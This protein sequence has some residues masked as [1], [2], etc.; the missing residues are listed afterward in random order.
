LFTSTT[1]LLP[2]YSSWN[3]KTNSIQPALAYLALFEAN[4]HY[5]LV[6]WHF[7]SLGPGNPASYR[8]PTRRRTRA[9][10]RLHSSVHLADSSLLV[11][12][13][14][15]HV[16]FD[17]FS[18]SVIFSL[19]AYQTFCKESLKAYFDFDRQVFLVQ[20]PQICLNSRL[21][22]TST[23]VTLMLHGC[24]GSFRPTNAH[25]VMDFPAFN[26]GAQ[27]GFF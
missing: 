25:H 14:Q 17:V 7:C 4:W 19:S 5:L 22:R 27:P 26:P 23:A 12:L 15:L 10:R 13:C 11:Q 20:F 9:F 1:V 18:Q 3:I 21:I 6:V 2:N 16:S 8:A 24:G